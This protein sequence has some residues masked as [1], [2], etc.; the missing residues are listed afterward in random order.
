M[1]SPTQNLNSNRADNF[2][3]STAKGAKKK[4]LKLLNVIHTVA[5]DIIHAM[6]RD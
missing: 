5:V 3:S 6:D 4:Q 1:R 2:A